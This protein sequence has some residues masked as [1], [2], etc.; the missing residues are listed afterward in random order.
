MEH[1]VTLA[2]NINDDDIVNKIESSVQNEVTKQISHKVTDR[3][4]S[5]WGTISNVTQDIIDDIISKYEDIV[6]QKSVEEVVALIKRSKKYKE[7]LASVVDSIKEDTDGNE[8]T[9]N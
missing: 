6:I 5:R 1:I 7:A 8:S 3:L 9:G 4:I 2:I